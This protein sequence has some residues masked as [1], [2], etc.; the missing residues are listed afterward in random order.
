MNA[1]VRPAVQVSATQTQS[2]THGR[3]IDDSATNCSR[4]VNSA[5]RSPCSSRTRYRPLSTAVTRATDRSG[6]A[7]L[8]SL[9]GKPVI[10]AKVAKLHDPN[11]SE[12]GRLANCGAPARGSPA[13][14]PTSV[15]SLRG[16]GARRP[17]LRQSRGG[18]EARPAAARAASA[19]PQA[20]ARAWAGP[21]RRHL[22]D[23]DEQAICRASRTSDE[24]LAAAL[25]HSGEKLDCEHQMIKLQRSLVS[26]LRGLLL[27]ERQ[28]LHLAVLDHPDG[29][30]RP[31]RPG[32]RSDRPLGGRHPRR[33]AHSLGR[34]FGA[35]LQDGR[36]HELHPEPDHPRTTGCCSRTRSPPSSSPAVRT[37]CRRSPARCS[38]SSPRSAASSRSTPSSPTRA[39]GTPRTWRGTSPRARLAR[40]ARGARA[41]V[42]RCVDTARLMIEGSL[43]A[44][45]LCRGGRKGD[46]LDAGLQT[47]T[48]LQLSGDD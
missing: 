48:T 42:S 23:G 30:R 20:G 26:L 22:D 4:P 16:R 6:A 5:G 12:A 7:L 25:G 35:L 2:P 46:G 21:R 34:R 11:L 9:V 8:P 24:L 32:L 14:R 43:G 39:A 10:E 36:A 1:R 38:D 40:P 19:R 45:A 41:L 47:P 3:S 29:R 18:F 31:A 37:T 13:S 27:E 17:P 15:P 33:D 44:A 28:R